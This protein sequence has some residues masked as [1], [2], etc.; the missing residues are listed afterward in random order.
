MS[1]NC[2][3]VWV[4]SSGSYFLEGGDGEERL[5]GYWGKKRKYSREKHGCADLLLRRGVRDCWG[6]LQ[7]ENRRGFLLG[8]N[9][10]KV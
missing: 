5:A 3:G 9:L 4:A 8:D 2:F 6:R 10:L 1:L 7:L